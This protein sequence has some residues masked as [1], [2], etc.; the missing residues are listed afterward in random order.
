MKSAVLQHRYTLGNLMR[1]ALGLC[2]SQLLFPSS[3]ATLIHHLFP[4]LVHRYAG[5]QCTTDRLP[6]EDT[7]SSW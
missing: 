5:G 2:V 4:S 6:N 3:S 1:A 7:V